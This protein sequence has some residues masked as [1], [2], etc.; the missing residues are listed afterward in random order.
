MVKARKKNNH[1]GI[2]T[3]ETALVLALILLPLTFGVIEYGWLF[4]KSQQITNAA[5]NGARVGARSGATTDIVESRIEVLMAKAGMAK[6][7][8]GYV[9]TYPLGSVDSVAVGLP[10]T[11]TINVIRVNIDV[12]NLPYVPKPDNLGASVTMAKEGH[13]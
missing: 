6:S 4:L 13:N 1:R 3:L 2:A 7:K 11:V 5:R 8:C 9:V 10:L 12:L